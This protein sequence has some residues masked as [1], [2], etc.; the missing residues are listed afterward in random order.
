[1]N[2]AIQPAKRGHARHPDGIA[3]DNAKEVAVLAQF[4]ASLGV[5]LAIAG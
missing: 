5:G 3:L 2:A 4:T 1:M